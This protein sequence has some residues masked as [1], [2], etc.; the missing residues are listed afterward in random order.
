VPLSGSPGTVT[1]SGTSWRQPRRPGA[2]QVEDRAGGVAT[3]GRDAPDD[4]RPDGR[5]DVR[6]A[7]PPEDDRRAEADDRCDDAA[8]RRADFRPDGEPR[9]ARTAAAPA[10]RRRGASRG[11]G[12]TPDGGCAGTI[13]TATPERCAKN[14]VVPGGPSA[15]TRRVA[16]P[17][18]IAASVGSEVSATSRA[19]VIVQRSRTRAPPA[20]RQHRPTAQLP[21]IHNGLSFRKFRSR[22]S[23][24]C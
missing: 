17:A 20:A 22:R 4:E 14:G 8:A 11:A 21:P 6:A 12:A 7:G 9:S 3:D 16:V 5:P 1:S 19:T 10:P 18:L 13:T 24:P 23:A 15:A 2:G